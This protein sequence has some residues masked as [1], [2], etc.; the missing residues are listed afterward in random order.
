MD[1]NSLSIFHTWP[2]NCWWD[3][4]VPRVPWRVEVSEWRINSY[5]LWRTCPSH[6]ASIQGTL[7]L[8]TFYN[9]RPLRSII[10]ELD[11]CLQILKITTL[12]GKKSCSRQVYLKQIVRILNRIP[13]VTTTKNF[14]SDFVMNRFIYYLYIVN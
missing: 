9:G 6:L 12:R 8:T 13:F 14:Q 11:S 4:F 5:S 2:G 3:T 1:I 10:Y 7:I